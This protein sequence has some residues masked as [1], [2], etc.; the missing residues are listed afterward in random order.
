MA[1][2]LVP[3]FMLDKELW[4]HFE[5]EMSEYGPVFHAD[6]SLDESIELMAQRVIAEAPA[7]FVLIG[8]SLGGY[9]AREIARSVPDRV[10]A[11]ILVATSARADTPLQA[12]RKAAAAHLSGQ[13]FKGLS[14]QAIEASLHPSR[15]AD[16]ELI[17]RIRAMD[18]VWDAIRSCGSPP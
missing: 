17:D 7:R 1:L 14:R 10:S 5:A 16:V 12:Q 11:L 15:Q 18:S 6:L 9:V 13:T 2:V 8:F 4:T 3:G